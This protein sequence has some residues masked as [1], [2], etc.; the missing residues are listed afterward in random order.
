MNVK[1]TLGG[2]SSDTFAVVVDWPSY[3]VRDEND[4]RTRDYGL[5]GPLPGYLSDNTLILISACG[6]PV[7][8]I[9]AHEEFPASPTACSGSANWTAP[10]P[11][12]AW[13]SWITDGDGKFVDTVG[14]ACPDC[15]PLS[16]IPGALR[17]QPLST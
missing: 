4:P 3:A 10:I 2:I 13:G 11:Q 5:P 7:F 6:F 1:A 12:A 14:Y 15:T 17:G 8:N 9:A 16:N